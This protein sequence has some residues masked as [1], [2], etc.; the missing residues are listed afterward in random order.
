MS[1]FNDEQ[2]FTVE[3]FEAVYRTSEE[4]LE[5]IEGKIYAYGSPSFYHQEVSFRLK[6]S[7]S[8]FFQ[9]QGCDV[10]LAPFDVKL[11][12]DKMDSHHVIPDLTVICDKRGYTAGRK[13]YVGVPS[14]I[15]EVLSPSNHRHD[16]VTKMNLYGKFGISEYWIANPLNHSVSIYT[17]DESGFYS[18]DKVQTSGI[19]DS[20]AYSGLAVDLDWLFDFQ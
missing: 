10:V 13:Q 2:E 5:F 4:P 20:R 11:E 12:L 3:E 14:L 9:S 18:Q 1:V 6:E 7:F 15:V 17:L 19:L 16:L 8:K